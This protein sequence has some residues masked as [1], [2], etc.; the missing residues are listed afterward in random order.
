M[1]KICF[2]TGTRA[3]YYL[4][5][6][7]IIKL[8]KDESFCIY[9]IVTGTH[10]S[11]NHGLTY[12]QIESD[13]IGIDKQIDMQLDKGD[14]PIDILNSMSI[15][16]SQ[17]SIYLNDIHPDA[18]FILGDRYELLPVAIACL[19][20]NIPIIHCCAGDISGNQDDSI[21]HAISKLSHLFFCISDDSK[22]NLIQLGEN[23]D[24]ITVVGYPGIEKMCDFTEL[25]KNELCKKLNIT[26]NKYNIVIL[27]HPETL[28]NENANKERAIQI[29]NAL[30]KLNINNEYNLFF[31]QSNSD[32]YNKIITETFKHTDNINNCYYF[33]SLEH[34]LFL[35]LIKNSDLFLSNSSCLIYEIPLLKIPII[36]IGHRQNGRIEYNGIIHCDDLN[37]L[38]D[39]IL[40]TINT[41]VK[42]FEPYYKAMNTSE[43]IVNKLKSIDNF[44]NLIYKKFKIL[45]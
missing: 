36:N 7:T 18:V 38:Y 25:S 15:E 12:K 34:F 9:L 26:F 11:V 44:K 20:L 30:N 17:I 10:L 27:F 41:N 2:I 1:K 8:K 33:T 16:L 28:L 6:N 22:K 24:N 43:L 40:T 31:I 39:K 29:V 23:P 21:R 37:L 13:K 5:K 19:I 42:M 14:L 35:S 45:K 3:E 32:N 4:L